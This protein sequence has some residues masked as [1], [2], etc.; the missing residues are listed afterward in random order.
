MLKDIDSFR[1]I[2]GYP[3]DNGLIR[4]RLMIT[5]GDIPDNLETDPGSE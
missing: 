2:E 1:I 4:G 5:D 3:R